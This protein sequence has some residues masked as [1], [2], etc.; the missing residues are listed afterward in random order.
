VIDT[1]DPF[2]SNYDGI[3][4]E[5]IQSKFISGRAWSKVGNLD[6]NVAGCSVLTHDFT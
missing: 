6:A 5:E 3:S 1:K 2:R 4:I